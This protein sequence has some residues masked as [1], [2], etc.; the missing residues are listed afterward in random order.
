MLILGR[1]KHNLPLLAAGM[2]LSLRV[3]IAP[4]A[5]PSQPAKNHE[6]S[7]V[8]LRCFRGTLV[9]EHISHIDGF[10]NK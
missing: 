1:S 6:F 9:P 3:A 7:R 8:Q 4:I 10:Y 5:P 2:S